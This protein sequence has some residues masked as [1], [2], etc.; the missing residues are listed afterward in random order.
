MAT[1]YFYVNLN[2][3]RSGMYSVE[4][5][6]ISSSYFY[7]YQAGTGPCDPEQRGSTPPSGV[8]TAVAPA[9]RSRLPSAAAVCD[10]RADWPDRV[11]GSSAVS[12]PS[13]SRIHQCPDRLRDLFAQ[14]DCK[15]RRAHQHI[16]CSHPKLRVCFWSKDPE[17]MWT[18]KEGTFLINW[19][20]IKI[21]LLSNGKWPITS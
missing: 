1:R 17:N 18:E 7:Y 19:V 8:A 16:R 13:H 20:L 15:P 4:L 10:C 9:L 11:F 6:C 3:C 2:I 14:H 12:E 21:L 5:F